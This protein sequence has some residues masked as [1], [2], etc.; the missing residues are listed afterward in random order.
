MTPPWV[1][2]AGRGIPAEQA[3]IWPG[4]LPYNWQG[5]FGQYVAIDPLALILSN[6]LYV[7]LTLPDPPPIEVLRPRIVQVLRSM[8]RAERRRTLARIEGWSGW[9]RALGQEVVTVAEGI[10]K[11]QALQ[12]A[13]KR[14]ESA[15]D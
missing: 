13:G 12:S 9:L 4:E 11:Q 6:E 7:K 1:D 8:S 14:H 5:V 2:F 10:D 3:L 15:G